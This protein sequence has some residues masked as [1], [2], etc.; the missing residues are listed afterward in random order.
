MKNSDIPVVILCGGMGTRLRE[1]TEFLPKPMIP[2]GGK[3]MLVHII[4]WYRKF[5]F[6][7]F[8]LA[9]G[10]KQEIIKD[11]FAHYD[12]IN[13]DVTV[14]IGRYAGTRCNDRTH[15]TW[16]VTMVD[17][18][19]H[20]LKGGRLKQVEKYIDSDVF[21]CTYGDA[22]SDIDLNALLE[23][24]LSHKKLATVTGVYPEPRFGEIVHSEGSVISFSEK[25][26]RNNY[27]VNG[28]FMVFNKEVFGYFT[29]S[30]DL[31][32]GPMEQ[33]ATEKQLMVYYHNGFWKCMDNMKDLGDLQNLWSEGKAEWRVE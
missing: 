18:G 6:S 26:C 25:Q 1:Q 29:P 19:E 16:T 30:S 31:E 15:D 9:L 8:I 28:G 17:T 7:K 4:N 2:I 5:G 23:F 21:M 10:Y 33:W 11:Y 32:I 20:T 22:V 14:D 27:Y 24:H 3:P 12:I 13:N